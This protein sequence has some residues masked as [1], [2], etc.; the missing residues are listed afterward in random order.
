[1]VRKASGTSLLGPVTP[2]SPSTSAACPR[3]QE[4]PSSF[5][6]RME[7][8][9]V[10]PSF[11]RPGPITGSDSTTML[12]APGIRPLA[13]PCGSGP[14][15][16]HAEEQS[17]LSLSKAIS[18]TALAAL[19]DSTSPITNT[20]FTRAR[21]VIVTVLG[22]IRHVCQREVGQ[23]F[24][25]LLVRRFLAE[26]E[27]SGA[28]LDD[29]VFRRPAVCRVVQ[30]HLGEQRLRVIVG[31]LLFFVALRTSILNTVVRVPN[32]TPF[33]FSCGYCTLGQPATGSCA[34]PSPPRVQGTRRTP[35]AIIATTPKTTFLLGMLFIFQSFTGKMPTMFLN[36]RLP[37]TTGSC[38]VESE[39][40]G[41]IGRLAFATRHP[42]YW[43]PAGCPRTGWAEH[44]RGRW[45][46]C[47]SPLT[48]FRRSI[49]NPHRRAG[50]FGAWR[51]RCT[52]A[53]AA[54]RGGQ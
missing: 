11:A 34:G 45:R 53:L 35:K 10:R 1:M 21:R 22:D 54:A 51:V 25:N 49:R 16:R 30:G 37:R 14:Y 17:V 18:R 26:T 6:L 19:G 46:R 2:R 36:S 24:E 29:H 23:L 15:R 13:R 52:P 5:L 38:Q 39:K 42:G 9:E 40:E 50:L 4:M 20:A 8:G 32:E 33:D 47:R 3:F 43:P 44:S 12:F 28:G 27:I 41:K 7:L 31:E 48:V